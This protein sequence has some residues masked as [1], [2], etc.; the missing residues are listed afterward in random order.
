[1]VKVEIKKPLYGNFV[2][3]N[4]KVLNTAVRQKQKV[5]VC[6]PNGCAVIDPVE[7]VKT[8]KRMEKV[9]KFPDRPMVLYGNHVPIKGEQ[10]NQMTFL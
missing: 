3:I 6:L 9:F 4:L 7:W 8:G 5:E 10:N 2:Y 1:M